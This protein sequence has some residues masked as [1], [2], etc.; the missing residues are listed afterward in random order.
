[1]SSETETYFLSL[2][3]FSFDQSS[4]GWRSISSIEGRIA[5]VE[6]YLKT[7]SQNGEWIDNTPES[8]EDL[9]VSLLHW[10]LGQLYGMIDDYDKAILYM[11][12]SIAG[13]DEQWDNYANATIMF[14]KKDRDGFEKYADGENYNS[15]TLDNL[16]RNFD[17]TYKEAY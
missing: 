8:D 4:K 11:S 17:R 3:P 5:A 13:R 9:S 6:Q 14:L 12:L 2:D 15:K 10:H 1:M 7:Y 16:R